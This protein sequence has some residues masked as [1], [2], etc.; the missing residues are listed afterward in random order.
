MTLRKI[1][2]FA[3]ALLSLL[4]C[5]LAR[6][7]SSTEDTSQTKEISEHLAEKLIEKDIAA[8]SILYFMDPMSDA[9]GNDYP[10]LATAAKNA[11]TNFRR[12]WT[13]ARKTLETDIRRFDDILGESSSI[14]IINESIRERI[15]KGI[16][17]LT[18]QD[19][20]EQIRRMNDYINLVDISNEAKTAI[21]D[22]QYRDYPEK[23]LLDGFKQS[24]RSVDNL[25]NPDVDFQLDYP[26]SW[27]GTWKYILRS[28]DETTSLSVSVSS[29]NEFAN[30]LE[31]FS[32]EKTT[33]PSQATTKQF[34]V[35]ARNNMFGTLPS[36]QDFPHYKFQNLAKKKTTVC[37][38]PAVQYDQIVHDMKRDETLHSRCTTIFYKGKVIAIKISM[39]CPN[40]R[41]DD[42]LSIIQ[43][44]HTIPLYSEIINSLVIE[45]V[46][47]STA[48]NIEMETKDRCPHRDDGVSHG[49]FARGARI[50]LLIGIICLVLG[51]A[52]KVYRS[53]RRKV[54]GKRKQSKHIIEG[55][56]A[57]VEVM[58]KLVERR[59]WMVSSETDEYYI[60]RKDGSTAW[61]PLPKQDG[62]L[63][64]IEQ[65]NIQ[66]V[67]GV[68]KADISAAMPELYRSAQ[69]NADA[70]VFRLARHLEHHVSP[71][72]E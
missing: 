67:T 45:G 30:P 4:Q 63:S 61:F 32:E 25:V 19:A 20:E 26:A 55:R 29:L 27:N 43:W 8:L 46:S 62:M 52:Y 65:A 12:R 6:A 24:W 17:Y 72:K 13:V 21:L 1:S 23:E 56:T 57:S 64:Q 15:D 66:A 40:N 2:A 69:T 60:Y 53:T 38:W 39:K 47:N 33:P 3:L 11:G 51:A 48:G 58:R 54:L 10:D 28:F 71:T 18:H 5:S 50:A 42:Q 9:I 16:H 49:L 7:E 44:R 37:E 68:T 59:G 22:A 41:W 70:E 31:H 34:N 36:F 35:L 14:D